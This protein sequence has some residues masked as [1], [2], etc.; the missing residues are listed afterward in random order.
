MFPSSTKES[1]IAP[2]KHFTQL[3]EIIQFSWCSHQ[4]RHTVHTTMHCPGPI[5]E[6]QNNSSFK[7][8]RTCCCLVAIALSYRLHK[9]S[10]VCFKIRYFH[11]QNLA[12]FGQKAFCKKIILWRMSSSIVDHP[13]VHSQWLLPVPMT[14]N[15]T[16][17]TLFICLFGSKTPIPIY[18]DTK[19]VCP[20]L[21]ALNTSMFGT[22]FLWYL[23][24]ESSF[25]GG[26][27]F[28]EGKVSVL[29]WRNPGDCIPRTVLLCSGPMNK[30]LS[31]P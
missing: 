6:K 8:V 9:Q 1:F 23:V 2:F 12:K 20:P 10:I 29:Y 11:G 5:H 4:D 28:S 24:V 3:T 31:G 17:W 13:V 26:G 7:H 18:Y 16:I 22:I 30:G 25:L 27:L 14:H 15:L 19:Y 21:T